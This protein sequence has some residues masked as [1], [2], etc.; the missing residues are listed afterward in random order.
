[1]NLVHGA[2]LG[3]PISHSLSPA[4]HKKAFELLGISGD[5]KAK[6]VESG[7][8]KDFLISEGNRYSY[9]SLTMPLKEEVLH[10]EI[11][12]STLVSRISSANTLIRNGSSFYADS[13]DGKGFLAALEH[14]GIFEIDSIMVLGAGATARALIAALDGKSE[15]ISIVL[16]SHF[17][18]DSL[19]NCVKE[20]KLIFKTWDNSIEFEDHALVVNT[21]PSFAAD[22]LI[23]DQSVGQAILFDV[24]YKPWPTSLA[25]YWL[26]QGSRV[27]SG[28]ELLIYQGIE[29]ISMFHDIPNREVLAEQ[30]RNYLHTME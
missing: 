12:T 4:L 19:R 21:T 17:R 29:Q 18:E 14:S 16:R 3:S 27:I 24:I 28:L 5:Y 9:L 8:L 13:T 10:C 25:Q 15:T 30:I 7:N 2:V 23:R 11:P 1:M 6:E 26:D 22:S 20:S